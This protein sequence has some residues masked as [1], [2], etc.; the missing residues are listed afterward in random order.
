MSAPIAP[1]GQASEHYHQ[2]GWPPF[3]LP[4]GKKKS[5]PDGCTGEAG[6]DAGLD[7]IRRWIAQNGRKNIGVRM[8]P[9]VIGIDVDNY[10]GKTGGA[11]L[12]VLEAKLGEVPPT[13]ISTSREDGV[14][15][16][17]FF[18]VPPGL[19]WQGNLSNSIEIIQRKH[20]YAV[21]EPSVHPSGR[22]YRWLDAEWQPTH[23]PTVAELPELPITWVEYLTGGENDTG[24]ALKKPVVTPLD[25]H[26]VLT[27]GAPCQAMVKALG[28]YQ[29][30]KK[31]MARHDAMIET[32]QALVRLGE[33]GHDGAGEAIEHLRAQFSA[34]VASERPGESSGEFQRGLS[35]AVAVALGR[36]TPEADRRCC[37]PAVPSVTVLEPDDEPSQPTPPAGLILPVEFYER[38]MLRKIREY[39]HSRSAPADPVLYAN[40]ARISGMVPHQCRLETGIGSTLGASLDLFVADVGP[41]G[42]GKSKSASVAKDIYL[43]S[44]L[45]FADGLP[46]GTGEGIVEAF[47]GYEERDTGEVYKTKTGDH[48]KGDPKKKLV[49]CQVRHNAFIEVDEGEAFNELASRNGSTLGP[50][51]RTAW[52]GGTVGNQNADPNRNRK[53]PEGS[54]SLGMFIGFQPDTVLPLLRDEA[55]GTPQ[56][57]VYCWTIDPT[58]PL[59]ARSNLLP[60]HFVVRAEKMLLA[61]SIAAEVKQHDYDQGNGTITVPRLDAHR[62]LTKLK[63]AAL[64]AL[65]EG[66]SVVDEEDWRLAG[67][68]WDTSCKVRDYALAQGQ[69]AEARERHARNLH[70]ADREGMAEGA[71]QQ[72]R[73]ASTKVARVARLI[74]KYVHDPV[75]PS[76]TIGEVN[77]RLHSK[78]HRPVFSEA[79][80]YA[81]AEGWIEVDGDQVNPG[82]SQP[83]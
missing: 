68:M 22:R 38:P 61:P 60:R 8:P 54:Y 29:E 34:D 40:L 43:S 65:L 79:L 5:P 1:F 35:G 53:L 72:V 47:M 25:T 37:G 12:A 50:T 30:R 71:R 21:V 78:E 52:Y 11:D 42:S 20:R 23:V 62:N 7:Q 73:D 39:A 28:K 81:A 48:D 13:F 14:S 16:I 76:R 26:A 44:I 55:A 77:R 74:A 33:Q 19:R 46:L 63:L 66:R 32:Q 3:P 24:P 2:K 36:R 6:I 45:D 58:R 18:T 57:F 83:A 56:R 10:D 75:K 64:L 27:P 69:A 9:T 70:Y 15:G 67:I 49:R 82:P 51:I 59:D 4:E 80:D 17:R 31:V 41:P